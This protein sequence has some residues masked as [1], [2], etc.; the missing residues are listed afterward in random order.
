[1]SGEGSG[2]VEPL[3]AGPRFLLTVRSQEQ[4]TAATGWDGAVLSLSF[5]LYPPL[6]FLRIFSPIR[7]IPS[8][9]LEGGMHAL[10]ARSN[11]MICSLPY[12]TIYL[13]MPL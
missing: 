3:A 7:S 6:P 11:S 13:D 8:T 1:V 5:F 9:E 10:D 4:C 12:F 2:G